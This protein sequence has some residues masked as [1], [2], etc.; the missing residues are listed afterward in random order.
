MRSGG[1]GLHRHDE[2]DDCVECHVEHQGRDYDLVHW[3]AGK[4]QFEHDRTGYGLEGGHARQDCR[5]CHKAAHMA[6]PG[7]LRAAGK[8]PDRT[9]LG[10][11]PACTTCHKDPHGAQFTRDCTTC[12]DT[13]TWKSAPLFDHAGTRYPLTGRHAAVT[14]A[15][16]H[17]ATGSDRPVVYAGI[18]HDACTACHRDPHAGALGP[19]CTDCHT[20]ESWRQVRGGAFDHNRTKYPLRGRHAAVTCSACHGERGPRPA[21][22][23]CTDCHRYDHRR[24]GSARADWTACEDCHTVEGFQPARFTVAAHD[25]TA[26][27][28]RGAH[29]AISCEPC[30]RPVAQ[31]DRARPSR[32]VLDPAAATCTACHADPHRWAGDGSPVCTT[33]HGEDSWRTVGFDHASTRFPLAGRHTDATCAGCH[34][35]AAEGPLG[36]GGGTRTCVECHKDVHE[37]T[38]TL[39]ADCAQCHDT[40]DWLAEKFDHDQDSLFKLAGA[41]AAV[42]CRACHQA[43]E[44]GAMRVFRP[45]PS[46]CVACHPVV[47]GPKENP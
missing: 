9:F 13:G 12:H 38:M 24:P 2:F 25:T 19:S 17:V 22:A 26:F 34:L 4:D 8:D 31:A 41:H 23:N 11:D 33:C 7:A 32:V 46:E 45:L 44:D 20:T 27:P 16:C 6:D 14:C 42:A 30:H 29:R 1:P 15:Q 18:A 28:L 5:A 3:P 43:G 37:G 21:F 39:G 40:I 35:A 47:P 36:F 10:L